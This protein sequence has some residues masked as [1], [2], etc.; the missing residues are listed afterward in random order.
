MT[1]NWAVASLFKASISYL[2]VAFWFWNCCCLAIQPSWSFIFNPID[3]VSANSLIP[4]LSAARRRSQLS[5]PIQRAKRT[6]VLKSPKLRQTIQQVILTAYYSSQETLRQ[7][8]RFSA[9]LSSIC[10]FIWRSFI[11]SLILL[12]YTYWLIKWQTSGPFCEA[13]GEVSAHPFLLA[14]HQWSVNG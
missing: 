2:F 3:H 13:T 7:F 4:S 6:R 5:Q 8:L 14:L 10:K 12:V 11:T 1:S 9:G